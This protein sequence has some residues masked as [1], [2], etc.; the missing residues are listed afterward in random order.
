M[1]R[2][3]THIPAALTVTDCKEGEPEECGV[4]DGRLPS[5]P[6]ISRYCVKEEG[7]EEEAAGKKISG[8]REHS[9]VIIINKC[10]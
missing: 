8:E 10:K 9:E 6:I 7:D 4:T 2:S 3:Y 1:G 5:T